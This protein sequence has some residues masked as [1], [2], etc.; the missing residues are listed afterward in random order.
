MSSSPFVTM[1]AC[2]DSYDCASSVDCDAYWRC[3]MAC[4]TPDCKFSCALGHEAGVSLFRAVQSDYAGTCSGPCQY[5]N[6]WACVGHVG[7][8][9]KLSNVV[10]LTVPVVDFLAQGT[11]VPGETVSVC[12][13]CPCGSAMSADPLLG[14][15]G[16]T[17]D[18]GLVTVQVTQPSNPE[19]WGLNGCVQVTSATDATV[20]YYGYWGYPLSEP[21]VNPALG[22]GLY[23]A[24]IAAQSA[25]VFTPAELVSATGYLNQTVLPDTGMIGA[26]VFDCLDNPASGVRVALSPSDPSVTPFYSLSGDA[27]ATTYTGYAFFFNVPPSN[28]YQLTAMPGPLDGGASS[29]VIVDV[30]ANTTTAAGMFPTP[31]VTVFPSH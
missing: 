15:A 13:N 26:S 12:A 2:A 30:A 1:N 16:T 8:P 27:G 4:P 11:P 17:D 24:N 19:N 29:V 18:A 6:Y 25:Q 28:G 3:Y 21:V 7:W 20:P 31:P 23:S 10:A 5:G 14:E 9:A 22:P